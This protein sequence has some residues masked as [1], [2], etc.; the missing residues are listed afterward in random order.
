MIIRPALAVAFSVVLL[1]GTAQSAEIT[2]LSSG[3]VREIVT[4]LLPQFEKSS[5]HQVKITW[6]G[7][8]KIKKQIGGGESYD[9][10]IV[11]APVIDVFIKDG[12]VRPGT[13][14]DLVRSGVGVAIRK[15]LP[16]P[17]ISSATALKNTLLAAKSVVY[18]T[19][20]SG[21]YVQKMFEKLGIADQ[22]GP[23]S[24]QTA[25]GT[26][27]GDYLERGEAEIG[28]QQIAELIHESGSDYV[29]PLPPEI[30]NITV[31]SSGVLTDAKQPDTAKAFQAFLVSPKN[32]PVI[33]KNGMEPAISN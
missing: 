25:S 29:G 2:V 16:K 3:A 20:P 27:V 9:L 28:F 24:K 17:D 19:G 14:I 18:S 23:K 30:Q 21:V 32:V 26:R 7:T 13:R 1:S 33:K 10:V 31:F 4:D 12:E 6:S 8:A 11:G 15:G 22:M 5:G